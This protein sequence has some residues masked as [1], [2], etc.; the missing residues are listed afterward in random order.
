MKHILRVLSCGFFALMTLPCMAQTQA[1]TFMFTPAIGKMLFDSNRHVKDSSF[2]SVSLGYQFDEIWAG[3]AMFGMFETKSKST[4]RSSTGYHFNLNGLYHLYPAEKLNPY[5]IGG[6]GLLAAEKLDWSD[7][8]ALMQKSAVTMNVGAG[9]KY[10]LTPAW[11]LRAEAREFIVRHSIDHDFDTVI[12]VGLTWYFD[13]PRR[14]KLR[15]MK[16]VQ[17][18]IQKVIQPFLILAEDRRA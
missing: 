7:S 13:N 8:D 17:M 3:E 1:E 16:P 5:V 10:D 18:D 4:A 9:L 2:Y 6:V 12:N 15:R 14:Q 11:Q